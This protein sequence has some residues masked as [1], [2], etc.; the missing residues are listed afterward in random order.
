MVNGK[1]E[2]EISL[3]V[4]PCSENMISIFTIYRTDGQKLISNRFYLNNWFSIISIKSIQKKKLFTTY[5]ST[6]FT[7]TH[8]ISTNHAFWFPLSLS[9]FTTCSH[10]YRHRSSSI[11]LWQQVTEFCEGLYSN[12]VRSPF[13]LNFLID[14]YAERCLDST[15]PLPPDQIAQYKRQIEQMC[16]ELINAHDNIR[17]RYWNFLL[18][19]FETNLKM[20]HEQNGRSQ[21]N[22]DN[23]DDNWY[24]PICFFVRTEG[25]KTTTD[26]REYKI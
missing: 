11:S 21:T 17:G 6:Q 24:W 2:S 1:W 15:N 25:K 23:D 26:A 14:L 20:K 19:K 10:V 13:L 4:I 12:R 8:P 5:K 7:P 9:L 16:G 18:K 3:K 22:G